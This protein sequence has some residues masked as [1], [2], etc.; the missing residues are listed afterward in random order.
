MFGLGILSWV[1]VAAGI[2]LVTVIGLG[3]WHYTSL[4]SEREALRV[5]T[6]IQSQELNQW[7]QRWEETRAALERIEELRREARKPYVE[8]E[9]I[10]AEHDLAALAKAKPGLIEH[11]VNRATAERFRMFECVTDPDCA[12]GADQAPGD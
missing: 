5:Q 2:A 11:R 3:Y 6:E 7:A 9:R 12:P 4:L 1:K 8:L 10:L